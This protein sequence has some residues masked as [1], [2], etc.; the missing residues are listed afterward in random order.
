M[1]LFF[2][3][4]GLFLFGKNS[5]SSHPCPEAFFEPAFL[6][7]AS[8]VG[9]DY[10]GVVVV[11]FEIWGLCFSTTSREESLTTLTH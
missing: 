10:A 7:P 5:V 3:P 9:V 4:D 2:I 6:T 11:A 1:N 8:V